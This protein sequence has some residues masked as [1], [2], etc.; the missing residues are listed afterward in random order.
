MTDMVAA[1]AAGCRSV[2]VVIVVPMPSTTLSRV[3]RSHR[4]RPRGGRRRIVAGTCRGLDP[5]GY[6]ILSAWASAQIDRRG[7]TP[8]APGI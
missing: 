6:A 4:H 3:E 7:S 2:R 5:A 1:I 8:G